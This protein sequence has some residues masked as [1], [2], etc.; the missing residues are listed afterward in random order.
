M[1]FIVTWVDGTYSEETKQELAVDSKWGNIISVNGLM[2]KIWDKI[3]DRVYYWYEKTDCEYTHMD[4]NFEYNN[5]PACIEARALLPG[6]TLTRFVG[7]YGPLL[8]RS[9]YPGQDASCYNN[10]MVMIC[11]TVNALALL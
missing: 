9:S 2:R 10:P 6:I 3:E 8:A 5:K 7:P 4:G 11:A 1:E